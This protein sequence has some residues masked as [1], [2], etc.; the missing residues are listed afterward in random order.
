MKLTARGFEQ[1][2]AKKHFCEYAAKRPY[3]DRSI[4]PLRAEQ[5]FWGSVPACGHILC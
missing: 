4:I 3:I 1:R 5:V 2:S